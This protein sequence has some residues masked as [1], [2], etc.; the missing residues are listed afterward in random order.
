[1]YIFKQL[2]G[3]TKF[4]IDQYGFNKNE[5]AEHFAKLKQKH[6]ELRKFS[7]GMLISNTVLTTVLVIICLIFM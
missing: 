4:S 2:E 6:E 7:I 1:M 5:V 3:F